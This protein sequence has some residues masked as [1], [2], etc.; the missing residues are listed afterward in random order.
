MDG[1][2]QQPLR[3]EPMRKKKKEKSYQSRLEPATHSSENSIAKPV[4]THL[5]PHLRLSKRNVEGKKNRL[6]LFD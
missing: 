1:C 3:V 6:L 5:D 2:L 4:K